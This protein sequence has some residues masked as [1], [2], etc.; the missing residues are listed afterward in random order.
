MCDCFQVVRKLHNFNLFSLE[1]AAWFTRLGASGPA[2]TLG[3]I[4][5]TIRKEGRRGEAFSNFIP[6][7]F[8]QDMVTK[9]RLK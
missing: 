9:K 7:L 2:F 6:L 5:Y 1:D 4:L 3:N 8:L